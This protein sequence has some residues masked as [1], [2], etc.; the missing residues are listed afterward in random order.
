MRTEMLFIC[1][2]LIYL[3]QKE[4]HLS[5]LITEYS[6]MLRSFNVRGNMLIF[7]GFIQAVMSVPNVVEAE[8]FKIQNSFC[9]DVRSVGNQNCIH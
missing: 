4:Y 3:H 9:F 8:T 1:M 7:F 5:Y 2:Q 6:T